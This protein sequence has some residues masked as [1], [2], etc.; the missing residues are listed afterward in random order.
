MTEN[1]AEDIRTKEAEGREIVARAKREAA[2][3]TAAARTAAEQSV[4][5]AKQKS[6]RSFREQVKEAEVAAEQN[7][8]KLVEA[9][10]AEADAFY[11]S[12][13]DDSVKVVD[14]LFKE[15]VATNGI[16]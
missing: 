5:E 14:W 7:A 12:K 4:K 16:D 11:R 2:G 10:K 6:H 3:I 13:Q 8:V 9:G 1:V 15:V